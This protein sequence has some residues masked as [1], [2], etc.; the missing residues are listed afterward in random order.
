MDSI[1]KKRTIIIIMSVK[2]FNKS[3]ASLEA[4][5]KKDENISMKKRV[6][7]YLVCFGNGF[8]TAYQ[9]YEDYTITCPCGSKVKISNFTRHKNSKK[10]KLY[11]HQNKV[12][13]NIRMLK[14]CGSCKK[15]MCE[16]K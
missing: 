16:N 8:Q 11:E 9:M 13:I 3:S 4:E 10:H 1:I 7:S 12:S 2:E 15:C 5:K 14:K 6:G